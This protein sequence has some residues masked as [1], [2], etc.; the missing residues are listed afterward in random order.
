MKRV[1]VILVALAAGV[2]YADSTDPDLAL[3]YR[4]PFRDP[5]GRP[6]RRP[7]CP[8]TAP[9]AAL[10]RPPFAARV[11]SVPPC[12]LCDAS[13]S[14]VTTARAWRCPRCGDALPP[15]ALALVGTEARHT[16]RH[17]APVWR[18]P[19]HRHRARHGIAAGFSARR[20]RRGGR[21]A[22]RHTGGGA[23]SRAYLLALVN[24]P[25]RRALRVG[26]TRRRR[27]GPCLPN[28]AVPIPRRCPVTGGR[29]RD[30][31]THYHREHGGRCSH[32]DAVAATRLRPRSRRR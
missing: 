4:A 11:T 17:Q 19:S 7:T 8:G 24:G 9:A 29:Y 30:R 16:Y 22:P 13:L 2:I 32:P 23:P 12:R 10:A 18:H 5:L 14:W 25:E 31:C 28:A 6:G 1:A 21:A 15:D 26:A 20:T 3:G 27:F